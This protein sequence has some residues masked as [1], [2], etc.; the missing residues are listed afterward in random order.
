MISL[1]DHGDFPAGSWTFSCTIMVIFLHLTKLQKSQARIS[2]SEVSAK[3]DMIN[4]QLYAQVHA[5]FKCL[6]SLGTRKRPRIGL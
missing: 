4:I 3:F 5:P 2:S 1:Q 6:I